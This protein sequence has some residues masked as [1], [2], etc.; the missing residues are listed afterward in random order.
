VKHSGDLVRIGIAVSMVDRNG[1]KYHRVSIED[2]GPGIPD[3]KKAEVFHR[4]MR[5]QTRM[6][7]TGLGLYIVKTLVESFGGYVKVEDRV[8]GD[9]TKGTRFVVYLPATEE[10]VRE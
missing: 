7:G 6:S 5:G 1:R 9:H 2:N 8:K 3:E 10:H 4:F